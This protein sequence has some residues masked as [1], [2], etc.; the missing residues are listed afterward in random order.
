MPYPEIDYQN[1]DDTTEGLGNE[2]GT[3]V[4]IDNSIAQEIANVAE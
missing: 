2:D 1:G 3:L 4:V